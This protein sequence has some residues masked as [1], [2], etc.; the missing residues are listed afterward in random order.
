MRKKINKTFIALILI[1]HLITV[2]L[3]VSFTY[4][5]AKV[6]S[7]FTTVSNYKIE[8]APKTTITKSIV[9]LDSESRPNITE[10]YA[11]IDKNLNRKV[12]ELHAEYTVSI[13]K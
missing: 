12:E 10:I 9:N 7:S 3:S 2:V 1:A 13:F 4:K 11:I 8:Q 6:D 5:V